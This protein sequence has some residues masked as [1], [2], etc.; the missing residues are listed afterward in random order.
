MSTQHSHSLP[1][2]QIQQAFIWSILLNVIFTVIEAGY[3]WLANSAS[4]LADAG[5]NLGD[6]LSLTLA[7]LANWLHSHQ[8]TPR[9]SYGYKRTTI[10]ATL[11]NVLLMLASGIFIIYEA[12]LKFMHPSPMQSKLVVIIA[13]IGILVNGGSALL[14]QRSQQSD[15]NLKGAYL[16]L[17]FDTL[18]SLGVVVAAIVNWVTDW[19][20]LDPLVALLIGF[21]ILIATW[22]MVRDTV[23][24]NLD[25]VPHPID[26]QQVHAY[27]S[28][29][30]GVENLHDLHI[31]SVST[32]QIA[33]T[34]HLVVPNRRF[35]DADHR[36]IN[37]YLKQHF[38]IDHVT[39]Q[40]EQG[41]DNPCGQRLNC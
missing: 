19:L 36:Q 23:H 39:L 28:S 18:V 2:H 3:A 14:F 6:V 29:L 13:L 22:Q 27:L 10:L 21:I 20:W 37:L 15:L 11:L 7:W 33:L 41:H 34:A 25:A 9:Y 4:L 26:S 35:N 38:N 17:I 5:H 31:W 32:R 12:I 40:V 16:H 30:P 24:L 8:A 1:S